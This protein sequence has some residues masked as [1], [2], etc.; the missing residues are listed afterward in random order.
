MVIAILQARTSSRRLPG[1]VLKPLLGVPMILRELERIQQSR[2]IDRVVLATSTDPS[3]DGLTTAVQAFG[4]EVFR[5]SLSDP[6]DRYYR[7]ASQYSADHVVRLTGDC[8]LLDG[9]VIDA[10]IEEHLRGHHDYTS[11]TLT[12]TYPDGLDTEVMK[13]SALKKAWQEAKMTSEREHV[14]PYVLKHPE[15]FQLGGVTNVADYSAMRWTVDE[16]EDYRFVVQVYEALYPLKAAFTMEDVI[17]LIKKRPEL[18][19]INQN[20]SRNEGLQKSL[21]EDTVWKGEAGT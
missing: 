10:V 8:P 7:C 20:F 11:N 12:L 18:A 5:G 14:T 4:V 17:E 15:I 13:F 9:R 6:L 19:Q 21:R 3:D 16:P 2:G 1:K